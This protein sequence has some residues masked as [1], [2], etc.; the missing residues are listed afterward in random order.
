MHREQL[1]SFLTAA[2]LGSFS[3]AG[4]ARFL[5]QSTVSMQV[6]ALGWELGVRLFERLG[7]RIK[8]TDAGERFLR[9]AERILAL[10]EAAV[11]FAVGYSR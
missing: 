3:R 7:R 6:G 2:Q 10:V 5:A 1:R 9:F 11:F 4:D 8:L